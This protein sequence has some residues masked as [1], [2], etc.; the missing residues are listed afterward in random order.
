MPKN[1]RR[2][3]NERAGILT[4][5]VFRR[6]TH[7]WRQRKFVLGNWTYILWLAVC[8]GLPLIFLLR[9]RV[10][11]WQRRRA[12]GWMTLG[13]LVGGWVWDALSIRWE[14]WYYD[15]RHIV[16]LW[17]LGMPIEEW[18]WVVGVTLMFGMVT[19]VVVESGK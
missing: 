6:L 18:L 12:L 3:H 11:I 13:S 14:I 5:A 16:G 17:M 1:R 2:R 4:F 8:I 19:V 15:P 10:V 7:N 9:W